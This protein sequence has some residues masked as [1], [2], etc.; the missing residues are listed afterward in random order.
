LR[1]DQG[2]QFGQQQ[3]GD[4][5]EVALPLQ[6][7][8]ELG[9]ICLEPILLGV[10][11]GGEPQV[12]NHR[13]DIVFKLRNFPARIDFDRAGELAFGHCRRDLG[14]GAETAPSGLRRG[15]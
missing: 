4:A 14:D 15:D 11:L 9:K 3:P 6:Q 7:A 5:R 12:G 8:G 10:V 13:V 2:R 1:V